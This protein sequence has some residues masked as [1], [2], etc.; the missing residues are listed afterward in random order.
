MCS[1]I[2]NY[3]SFSVIRRNIFSQ[4]N[5]LLAPNVIQTQGASYSQV[6][7]CNKTRARMIL[8]SFAAILYVKVVPVFPYCD[9]KNGG[10]T[11]NVRDDGLQF[12]DLYW[13][14]NKH[15]PGT[16]TC[17]GLWG[18]SPPETFEILKLGNARKWYFFLLLVFFFY[19]LWVL[20]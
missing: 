12:R 7:S 18:N 8:R 5:C 20:K 4:R 19:V 3:R 13:G 17:R 1:R 9:S 6:S 10:L 16:L 11:R 15:V 2:I 14:A